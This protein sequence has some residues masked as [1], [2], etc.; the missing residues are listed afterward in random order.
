VLKLVSETWS[1]NVMQVLE[2][3]LS[4]L[5]YVYSTILELESSDC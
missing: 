5:K 2:N 4:D 3:R 1:E